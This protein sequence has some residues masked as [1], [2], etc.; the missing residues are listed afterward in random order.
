M[1]DKPQIITPEQIEQRDEWE[2]LMVEG[3]L[4]LADGLTLMLRS[5]APATPY[6]IARLEAAFYEVQYNGADLAE[7]F[8]VKVSQRER[9]KH[10]RVTW[11]NHVRFHVDAFHQQGYS[12]QDPTYYDNTA[13][14]KA[15]E[16]LGRSPSQLCDTY[17]KG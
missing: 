8:G 9:K 5:G 3:G 17:Y 2:R 10:D 14:H 7:L 6:L 11:V 12:K 15:S 1:T 4:S 13:F 16:I